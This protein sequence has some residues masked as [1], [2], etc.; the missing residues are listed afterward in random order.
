MATIQTRKRKNGKNTYRV[1][2]RRLDAPPISRSFNLKRD[3]MSWAAETENQIS[4]GTF[5]M[6]HEAQKHTV[7]EM[8]ERYIR[9]ELLNKPRVGCDRRPHLKW[10][11]ALIGHKKLSEVS[12]ALL[13][14]M[15]DKLAGETT[16]RRNLR[17]PATVNRYLA[18]LS[19]V[20]SVAV[21]EWEWLETSPMPRVRKLKEPRGRRI[22]LP[23][24]GA[25]LGRL[26]R[27]P[28]VPG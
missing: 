9:T 6:R 22:S 19:H 8:I 4:E 12:T 28:R 24:P 20:F 3:A 7:A 13:V 18:I 10:W 25:R 15:R 11:K 1:Q 23:V 17:T 27:V 26:L 2:I 14:E 16:V 5:A 21:R